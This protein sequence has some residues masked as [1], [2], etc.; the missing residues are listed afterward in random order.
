M[1]RE[2]MKRSSSARLD[3]LQA[4]GIVGGRIAG[5]FDSKMLLKGASSIKN[6]QKD[7][8]TFVKNE[9]YAENLSLLKN[10]VVLIPD[11]LASLSEKYPS[12]TYIVVADLPKALLDLQDFFYAEKTRAL[13]E[14]VIEDRVHLGKSVKIGKGTLISSGSY[15][16]NNVKIGENTIIYPNTY[17]SANCVIGR[18]CIIHAGAQIGIDGFRFVQFPDQKTVRKML[19]VGGVL[20]GD[21]VEIGAN[22]TIARATFENDATLLEDDVKLDAQVHIGHNSRIGKRTLIAAQSCISGSVNIGEDVWIG[23]GVTVSNNVTIGDG[24][25]ILLNAVVAY[26][27]PAAQVVS[28][29]YA[30]PHLDWKKQYEKIRK[31]SRT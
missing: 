25:K 12:N 22:S 4:A 15:L 16:A 1:V 13:D 11:S 17:I 23:A 6:Y 28:G 8:I 21:R 9:E 31:Q 19:H 5:T 29:F 27:V 24:V 18:S 30:M 20:I 3:I 2:T 26:D 14:A 7:S 10:A